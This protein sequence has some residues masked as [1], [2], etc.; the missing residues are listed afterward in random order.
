MNVASQVT[1]LLAAI[2]VVMALFPCV[3]WLNWIAAPFCAV[4]VLLGVIGMAT[5]RDPETGQ[6][7]HLGTHL[8]AVIGGLL[9][10]G[11]STFRCLMGGGIL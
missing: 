2:F 1:L 4:P 11:I 6:S 7:I 3:G 5:E 10:G 9:L 8:A